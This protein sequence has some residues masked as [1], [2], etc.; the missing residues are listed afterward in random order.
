[1]NQDMHEEEKST[2]ILS[3]LK[4]HEELSVREMASILSTSILSV[5]HAIQ[6]LANEMTVL[7]RA[8]KY[9]LN[10]NN[11]PE[12]ITINPIPSEVKKDQQSFYLNGIPFTFQTLALDSE[13]ELFVYRRM[14]NQYIVSINQNHPLALNIEP[15]TNNAFT[16]FICSWIY[17]EDSTE[18]TKEKR[19]ITR[20]RQDIGRLLMKVE[21]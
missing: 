9:S 13:T 18:T 8:G 11:T 19:T 14:Q 21:A 5:K 3:L 2:M 17:C 12:T 15:N 1:M 6:S 10:L 20:L 4:K 16:K 7:Q